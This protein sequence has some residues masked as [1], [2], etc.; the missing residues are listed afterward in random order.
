MDISSRIFFV[1]KQIQRRQRRREEE[2]GGQE[3]VRLVA[4]R[5][6]NTSKHLGSFV[7][8][9]ERERA[10]WVTEYVNTKK[11]SERESV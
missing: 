1:E 11:V 10:T 2:R 4:P 5:H 6:H 3:K 7:G 9:R 8:K